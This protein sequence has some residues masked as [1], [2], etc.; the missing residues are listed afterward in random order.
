M[1]KKSI[2]Q[3][4]RKNSEELEQFF[5]F[6]KRKGTEKP[7]KGKGSYNRKAFKAKENI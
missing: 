1:K 5:A 6:R 7:K 2:Q 4:F 3:V